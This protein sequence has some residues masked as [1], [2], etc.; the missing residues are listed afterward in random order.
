MLLIVLYG[1]VVASNV[2]VRIIT[3]KQQPGTGGCCPASLLPPLPPLFPP[4]NLP[5]TQLTP[6]SPS[7]AL[8]LRLGSLRFE[9]LC[10]RLKPSIRLR[11]C[12][13]DALPLDPLATL[14]LHPL[15]GATLEQGQLRSPLPNVLTRLCSRP[16]SDPPGVTVHGVQLTCHYS[17]S[18]FIVALHICSNTTRCY[19]I[20]KYPYLEYQALALLV[21]SILQFL[22]AED[23]VLSWKVS[24]GPPFSSPE[25]SR[26]NSHHS[27]LSVTVSTRPTNS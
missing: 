9:T 17:F 18:F 26:P 21:C 14:K 12:E 7:R 24:L 2:N 19:R 5:Q 23:G 27:R 20:V 1:W 4:P 6:L 25:R 22:D 16:V 11:T 3:L 10:V 15:V 8:Q 13:C